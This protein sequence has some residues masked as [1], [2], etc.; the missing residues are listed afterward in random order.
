MIRSRVL[1]ALAI[2]SIVSSLS[3]QESPIP[4][5]GSEA[6]TLNGWTASDKAA[7]PYLDVGYDQLYRPQ[8][9]F[10]SRRNWLND[11]NGLVYLDGEYHLFFQHN[12]RGTRWGNMTWG[13]AVSADMVH[14][15]QLPHAILPYGGGTIFSGSA[16]VDHNNSLGL[17]AGNTKTLVAVFTHAKKPFSQALA[18]STN[19]GRTFLLWNAG[20]AVVPNNGYDEGERDPKVFWHE[21][22]RK[23]VMVLWVRQ[24]TPGRVL[25]FNST[26]L[27]KWKEV[28]QLDRNW[29]FE[30]MDMVQLPVDGDRN[31]T[32]W[33]LD[34]ASFEYEVG[35]FDGRAFTSD[36]VAHRGEYGPNFYAAQSFNNNP[37]ART[38]MIGWMRGQDTPF[39]R[40]KMPFNQQ[41]SF[42]TTMELRTTSEGVRLFRWP[43]QEIEQ[44]YVES[45]EMKMGDLKTAQSKLAGFHAE[46]LDF[47]IEFAASEKT[48]LAIDLR[49]HRVEY[50]D[51]AFF[52]AK[53]RIPAHPIDGT[54][55]LRTLVDRT[56]IEL[57]ANRGSAVATHYARLDAKN[58]SVSILSGQNVHF[59]S[60]TAHRLKSAWLK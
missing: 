30:C 34:D 13:H 46:L 8:F 41:M 4:N 9:H 32:R 19:R 17:Q 26:D 44:L 42:P 15:K 58:K 25:F 55:S 27:R 53:S 10:T 54:V 40:E 31:N 49:G 14:W 39:V 57:F 24:G 51:G 50:C 43:I 6:G 47:S 11:P 2:I 20:K 38:V 1:T 23:W 28:S 35:D 29:V 36:K 3:A 56:S 18:Y 7:A 5:S 52:Y 16:V 60:L 59:H 48:Q 37:D 12:P 21:A 33:L 22:S 45:V